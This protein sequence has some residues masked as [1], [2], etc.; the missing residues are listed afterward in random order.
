[1]DGFDEKDFEL[2]NENK[3]IHKQWLARIFQNCPIA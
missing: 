3:K 1:M 2:Q